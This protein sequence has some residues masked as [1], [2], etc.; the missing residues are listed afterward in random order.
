MA[1]HKSAKKRAR[2]T[3]KRTFVNKNLLTRARTAIKAL[4]G[5]IAEGDKTV[6]KERMEKAQSFLA[7][8]SLASNTIARKTSRLAR[9]VGQL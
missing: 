8:T 5:A 6:A 7:R 3:V 1:N 4:Q 2:Q 9:K